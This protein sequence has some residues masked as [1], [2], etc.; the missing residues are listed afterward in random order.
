MKKNWGMAPVGARAWVPAG[1]CAWMPAWRRGWLRRC[2][3][4]PVWR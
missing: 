1:V 4:A 3:G 2:F